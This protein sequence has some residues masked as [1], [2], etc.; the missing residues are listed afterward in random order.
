MMNVEKNKVIFI[1]TYKA[2]DFEGNGLIG[3]YLKRKYNIDSFYINGYD[4]EKHI[5]ELKPS[6]LIIDHL[7]WDHKKELVKWTSN[8]GVKVLLLFTEGYYYDEASIKMLIGFPESESINVIKYFSWN[9]NLK[10]RVSKIVNNDYASKYEITGCPRFDFL[11]NEKLKGIITPRQE[12]I[13]K[14]NIDGYSS[15]VTYMSTTPYQGYPFKKFESRYKKRAKLS[16]IEI[17]NFYDDNQNQFNNHTTI[18]KE[19]A[20]KNPEVLFFYKT[21]PSES[22]V[23]NCFKLFKDVS[24]IKIIINENVRPFL[25]YS[26]LIVQRNCTTALESWLLGKPVVQLNDFEYS[27]KSYS[28][29]DQFSYLI[30]NAEEL[31]VFI[32]S[33]QHKKWDR[34]N[35]EQFL[36]N[37]FYKLDGNAHKRVGDAIAKV[38]N[39]VDSND[40]KQLSQKIDAYSENVNLKWINKI[41]DRLGINRYTTLRPSFYL[42]KILNRNKPKTNT[43]NEVNIPEK[44]VLELY[45]K[46]DKIGF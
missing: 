20:I 24:N 15:I 4:V 11:T 41:K 18:I 37:I 28:E 5:I 39:Q 3:W 44:E 42:K 30:R 40:M 14:Y 1:T 17:K 23:D 9:N 12:F 13:K 19:V 32:K 45:K 2:R 7:T 36:E 31:D 10:E 46:I 25:F 33:E 43:D 8:L 22:Y 34:L 27:N 6:V 16:S 21:H 26:D 38:I 29:H 35:V